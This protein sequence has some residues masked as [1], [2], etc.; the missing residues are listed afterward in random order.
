MSSDSKKVPR[1]RLKRFGRMVG[2]SARAGSDLV[3]GRFKRWFGQ[4]EEAAH[5]DAA[6]KV[7]GTLGD[8]KG[9]ALKLGQTL[10]LGANQLPEDVREVISQLFSDAPPLPYADIAKVV[11]EELGSELETLFTEF[12][13]EP[14]AAASLGQVHRARLPSGEAVAV[15]VQYPGIQDALEDDLRNAGALVRTLGLG[16]QLLDQ[17]EYYEEVRGEVLAELDYRRELGNLQR[18]RELLSDYADLRL[19][20]G[21]EALSSARVLTLEYLEGPTL[22]KYLQREPS[23]AER[24]RRSEQLVRAT[25]VPFFRHRL[26]QTDTHPG[27]FIVCDDGSLGLLD[28]GSIKSFSQAFRDSYYQVVLAGFPDEADVALVPVMRA[29]GFRFSLDASEAEP[30]LQHISNI[31]RRPQMGPYDFADC[32]IVEDLRSLGMR[33]MYELMRVRPPPEAVM[34]YRAVAG[35]AHNLRHLQASGD[36]RPVLREVVASGAK[37]GQPDA[38]SGRD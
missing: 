20:Q 24:F 11:H 21:Y 28:F 23:N 13:A 27:N 17:T 22:H 5:L 33:R 4:K 6:K 30:L 36:F 35:V 14:F 25:F 32:R 2:M 26:M 38:A 18:F 7:L 3:G 19:P 31:V 37:A 10:S 1:G 29:G 34:F 16:S 8:M 9:A 12:E 15:K